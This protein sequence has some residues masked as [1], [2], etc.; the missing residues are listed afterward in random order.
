MATYTKGGLMGIVGYDEVYSAGIFGK[1]AI[2]GLLK[3]LPRIWA[4]RLISNIQNK[5]V[6]KPFYNPD[7]VREDITPIDAFRFFLGPGNKDELLKGIR[8]YE[9][10]LRRKAKA[11]EQPMTIAAS[12]E[13]PLYLLRKVMAITEGQKTD[14]IAELERKLFKAF[15]LANDATMNRNNGENPYTPEAD[16]EMYV[17]ALMI[18]RF[19]HNEFTNQQK[20][21]SRTF[22]TQTM[23]CQHFFEFVQDNDKLRDIYQDFLAEYGISDWR[24]YLR[25]IMSVVALLKFHTGSINLTKLQDEDQLIAETIFKRDSIGIDEII[26]E[27]DNIDYV[28]FRSRPF[29]KIAEREY[30]VIDNNFVMERLYNGLYFTFLELW[31]KRYPDR[32]QEF[33]RIYTTEFSEEYLFDG[34]LK[35]IAQKRQVF[36]LTDNECKAINKK[37]DSPPDFYIRNGKKVILFENKDVKIEK[38]IK[39][40]G[41]FDELLPEI[42]KKL[43]GEEINGKRKVKGVGQLVRNA[44]RI[45][46]GKFPWDKEADRDSTIYLVLVV[47]DH[48]QTALGWKNYLDRKL[49]D[50]IARQGADGKKIRPLILMD[51]GTL[52]VRHG[53]FELRGFEH[54]FED[55]FKETAFEEIRFFK[56]NMMLNAFNMTMSFSDYMENE[57]SQDIKKMWEKTL[58]N[59]KKDLN[60][61]RHTVATKTLVY[62]DFYDDGMTPPV[63]YLRGIDKEWLVTSI[64]HWISVDSFDSFSM[65][66]Y[67]G[68]RVLFQDYMHDSEVKQLFARLK[69]TEGQF[70]GFFHT[71][72]NHGALYVLLKKVLMLDNTEGDKDTLDAMQ[73]LFKA[74]LAENSLEMEYDATLLKDLGKYGELQNAAIMI[75]QDLLNLGRFGE[76]VNELSRM[77]MMKMLALGAY[78]NR[79]GSDIGA[80]FDRIIKDKGID[81]QFSMLLAMLMPLQVYKDVGGFREGLIVLM[82]QDY[83]KLD[84]LRLWN[85]FEASVKDRFIDMGNR[86]QITSIIGQKEEHEIDCFRSHPVIRLLSGDYLIVSQHLYAHLLFDGLKEEVLK[87]LEN[88][89]GKNYRSVLATDFSEKSLFVK[90]MYSFGRDKRIKYIDDSGFRK[91]IAA[92]DFV[93]KT[94]HDV[95]IFESKDLK[96]RRGME[97]GTDIDR[98]MTFMDEQLNKKKDNK[99]GNKGLTQLVQFM[100]EYFQGDFPDVYGCSKKPVKENMRVHPILVMSNRLFSVRGVNY[101]LQ[102][103]LN[104]RIDESEILRQRKKQIEGLIVMDLDMMMFLA[105]AKGGFTLFRNMM[106]S[107]LTQLRKG[108]QDYHEYSSFRFF[109][110]NRLELMNNRGDNVIKNDKMKRLSHKINHE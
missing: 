81:G 51:V 54:C 65:S 72:I 30:A 82:R 76:N 110:M 98:V 34:I 78:A 68:M 36:S 86:E 33:N 48:R 29:I 37:T 60:L 93:V 83:E 69:A 1:P 43:V 66:A 4:I 85:L 71:L 32:G 20:D 59:I 27:E 11:N 95:F 5:L 12:A 88:S 50:E 90:A 75:Q 61:G 38:A 102:H 99:K 56:G 80:A 10:Y 15:L 16:L 21:L 97:D 18:S 13:T 63:D 105:S 2:S 106:S 17:S 77:Q 47:A 46:D 89:A 70:H 26:S 87:Q 7:F 6:E 19:A 73:G 42:D 79:K 101:V 9:G 62:Q 107:Y 103:K 22:T 96:M 52:E 84:A 25:T 3:G 35:E 49:R 14:N 108:Q 67:N 31:K 23:K 44:K 39:E 41:R 74:V 57:R 40:G 45:Q 24:E 55:Y 91:G 28:A 109:T 8:N 53:N 94:R 100:E 104:E 58:G 92:P 64:C